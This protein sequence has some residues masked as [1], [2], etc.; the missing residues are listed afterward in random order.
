MPQACS[1]TRVNAEAAILD[2]LERIHAEVRGIHV[3]LERAAG[4]P[5][6]LAPAD[7]QAVASLLPVIAAAVM[8]RPFTIRE[9]TK[10][11]C[12]N[13]APALVLRAALAD[14]SAV[15]LG[16]LF[17]RCADCDVDGYSIT[18]LESTRFGVRWAVRCDDASSRIVTHFASSHAFGL[19]RR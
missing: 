3:A 6:R 16:K 13:I 10:H 4:A 11:A 14:T 19:N 15:K 2:A 17:R 12:L 9:L 5:R 7:R 18:A 8:G 1:G